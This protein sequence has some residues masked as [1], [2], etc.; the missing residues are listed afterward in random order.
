[1]KT[2]VDEYL[3]S[4]EEGR[5]EFEREYIAIETANE[6]Y[7]ALQNTGMS[8]AEFARQ[9]KRSKAYITRIFQGNYNLTIGTIAELAHH[10]GGRVKVS[11]SPA[12]KMK[13]RA[14]IPLKRTSAEDHASWEIEDKEDELTEGGEIIE[15]AG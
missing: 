10:L 6:L 12:R 5:T 4:S 2:W 14:V 8:K 15:L 11:F 9:T 3:E 1:M 13:K 7:Q